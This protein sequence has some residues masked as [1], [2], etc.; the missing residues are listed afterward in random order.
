MLAYLTLGVQMTVPGIL[1]GA[2]CGYFTFHDRRSPLDVA[3]GVTLSIMLLGAWAA[4]MNLHLLAPFF[5][6]RVFREE[7]AWWWFTGIATAIVAFSIVAVFAP[8]RRPAQ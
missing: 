3:S 4:Y 6:R 8:M 7:F 2:A 1:L 5:P